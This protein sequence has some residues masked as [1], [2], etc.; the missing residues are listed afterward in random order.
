MNIIRYPRASICSGVMK[1]AHSGNATARPA[2]SLGNGCSF[3]PE[4][5][6]VLRR[7]SMEIS[8]T[9]YC[10]GL[11]QS[12]CRSWRSDITTMLTKDV[13]TVLKTC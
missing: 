10:A 5:P 3:Y 8:L 4:S 2:R 13:T 12:N 1:A 6:V 7:P 11:I 9:N